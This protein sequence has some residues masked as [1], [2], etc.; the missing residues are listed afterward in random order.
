MMQHSLC[1]IRKHRKRLVFNTLVTGCRMAVCTV[2][3]SGVG[4][5]GASRPPAIGAGRGSWSLRGALA[6]GF[7]IAPGGRG[8]AATGGGGF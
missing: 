6:L 4:V 8:K 3:A 5:R 7:G 2:G 1:T